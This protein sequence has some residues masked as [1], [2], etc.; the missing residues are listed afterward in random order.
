[1]RV[2]AQTANVRFTGL[3]RVASK[4]GSGD[5][6]NVERK[7]RPQGRAVRT[8]LSRLRKIGALEARQRKPESPDQATTRKASDQWDGQILATFRDPCLYIYTGSTGLLQIASLR[9]APGPHV[10]DCKQ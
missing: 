1:M 2:G 10:G 7:T 5:A 3:S 4:I 9:G 8:V 6:A